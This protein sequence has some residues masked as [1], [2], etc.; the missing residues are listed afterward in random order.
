M[1]KLSELKDMIAGTVTAYPDPKKR[2][3]AMRAIQWRLRGLHGEFVGMDNLAC[4]FV[5]ESRALVFDGRDNEDLK[6]VFYQAALGD[7]TVEILPQIK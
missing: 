1:K 6:L 2:W 4:A 7:L 5:P 3:K